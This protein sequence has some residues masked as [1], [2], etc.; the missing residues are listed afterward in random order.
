VVNYDDQLEW[1]NPIEGL[2]HAVGVRPQRR[3]KLTYVFAV[4]RRSYAGDGLLEGNSFVVTR[5]SFL[6]VRKFDTL[7]DAKLYVESLYEL[8]RS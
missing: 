1:R 2:W 7:D 5:T 4:V 3:V 6:D 8:E